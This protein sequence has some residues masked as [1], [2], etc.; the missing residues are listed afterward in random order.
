MTGRV[1]GKVALI[2]G[3]ARGQGRSHAVRLASEGADIIA[4]D[5]VSQ[6]DTVPFAM[7]TSEDMAETVRLVEALDRRIIALTADVRDCT[8]LTDSVNRGVAELG[9]LD[10]VCANAGIFT[11]A[12]IDQIT[13]DE[14]S[15]V[16]DVNLTG[17]WHTLKAALPHLRAANGGSI[18]ITG[19]TAALHPLANAAGYVAAKHGVV[20]LM[21]SAALELAPD[22]IRVNAVHTGNV[23]TPMIRNPALYKLFLPDTPPDQR[24]DEAVLPAVLAMSA[25]PVPWVEPEDVSN[26]VLW[27][28]S[29]EARFVTGLNVIVDAG[30]LL[31]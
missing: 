10:I 27:L 18:I 25:M 7:G 3:A 16:L 14:W 15:D 28:A 20:G 12:P 22:F 26:A 4:V 31:L 5:R 29:D 1:A 6:I 13:E 11:F 21:K 30:R 17:A 8:A 9:R 19:S 24:T 23:N 2:T